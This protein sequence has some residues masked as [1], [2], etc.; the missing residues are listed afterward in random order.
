MAGAVRNPT[1]FSKD[2]IAALVWIA[3]GGFLFWQSFLLLGI[4]EA[5]ARGIFGPAFYPRLL[6]V[7]LMALGITLLIKDIRSRR[8]VAPDI[9]PAHETHGRMPLSL[10]GLGLSITA[11]IGL[12]FYTYFLDK[13]GY[14]LVTPPMLLGLMVLMGE[15]RWLM[16][17]LWAIGFS[18]GLY[19]LFRYA[20]SVILPEGLLY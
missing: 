17:L 13:I 4:E 6:A 12:L 1:V 2:G 16:M 18:T 14:L 10:S 5:S 15:R 8:P 19:L 9:V 20:L 11:F 7:L 3:F